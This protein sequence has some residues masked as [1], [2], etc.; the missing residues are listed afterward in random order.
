MK[1]MKRLLAATALVLGLMPA[2]AQQVG[3]EV[4]GNGPTD[5][6]KVYLL[7]QQSQQGVIDSTT[8]ANG[9]FAFRGSRPKDQLMAVKRDGQSW[10][11]MFFNDGTPV[12]IDLE[13]NTLKGSALNQRLTDYDLGTLTFQ[14]QMNN[15]NRQYQALMVDPSLTQEQRQQRVVQLQQQVMPVVEGLQ[16]YMKKIVSE[17]RDNIIPAAFMP[18]LLELLDEADVADVLSGDHAYMQHPIVVQLKQRYETMLAQQAA[19]Q[20][21]IG[22]QFTD[23]EENAPDGKPHKLSE[24][25]GRGHWVLIDFWASWCG[26][27]RGE[28]PNVVA[29]YKKYHAKGFDIVGLSFD[30]KRDAWVKAIA[31]LNMTWIH[32]SDLKG[33]QSVAGQVY[34]INSIPASLLVDPQGKIVARDL[35]GEALGRK[36][37]EI[38]GE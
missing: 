33:W 5:G 2:A 10:Q 23:L 11:V 34:G 30:N 4:T 35:R 20:R 28:M 12:R 7:D 21:I 16:A 31:D 6:E 38:F 25:V 15:L 19:K 22:Q 37:R 8:V 24:Y 3:Y 14:E 36:L 1:A 13:H 17:N 26:P 29:N 27:C 9:Q 32:L 18:S